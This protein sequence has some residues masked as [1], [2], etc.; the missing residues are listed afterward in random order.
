[1]YATHIYAHAPASRSIHS[2][3]HT[4]AHTYSVSLSLALPFS[5]YLKHMHTH[6]HTCRHTHALSP[7]SKHSSVLVGVTVLPPPIRS[8]RSTM[9]AHSNIYRRPENSGILPFLIFLHARSH[10]LRRRENS[11][12]LGFQSQT[13]TQTIMYA[14]MHTLPSSWD[15]FSQTLFKP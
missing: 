3:K 11:G 8:A 4:H 6:T 12:F 5:L 9:H 13:Q 2:H 10:A 14:A 15:P 1:M 7:Q